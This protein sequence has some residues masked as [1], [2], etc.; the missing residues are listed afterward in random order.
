VVLG[1]IISLRRIEAAV[2]WFGYIWYIG[3]AS[4]VWHQLFFG[5]SFVPG[6]RYALGLEVV[7]F[8]DSELKKEFFVIHYEVC[9]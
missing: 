2:F 8:K 1:D 6:N 7:R 9:Q 4:A 5:L 3:L